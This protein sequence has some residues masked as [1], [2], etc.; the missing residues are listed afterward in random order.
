MSST[1]LDAIIALIDKARPKDTK[2]KV[3][4]L[5]R[6]FDTAF[7]SFGAI[8]R[9][10][11]EDVDT[12]LVTIFVEELGKRAF[13]KLEIIALPTKPIDPTEHEVI[14]SDRITKEFGER[15]EDEDSPTEAKIKAEA[16][17]K[18]EAE[19]KAALLHYKQD[20]YATLLI[21]HNA[22]FP[23]VMSDVFYTT[24]YDGDV[25]AVNDDVFDVIK[26][27]RRRVDKIESLVKDGHFGSDAK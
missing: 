6:K 23:L 7:S 12:L 1:D 24:D 20:K 17:I 2:D 5:A 10:M 21:R 26:T 15:S 19:H 27:L 22:L 14:D 9:K 25:V 3:A 18:A 8:A 4:R 13:N 11:A 16:R